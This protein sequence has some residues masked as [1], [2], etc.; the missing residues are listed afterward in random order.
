MQRG[1]SLIEVLLALVVMSAGMLGLAFQQLEAA[2]MGTARQL[3]SRAVALSNELI[4]SI[5]ANP[6]GWSGYYKAPGTAFPVEIAACTAATS[7]TVSELAA[8]EL[9]D[10]RLK[11]RR[12]M[13]QVTDAQLNSGFYICHDPDPTD[14]NVCNGDNASSERQ[15]TVIQMTWDSFADG[16]GA[17]TTQQFRVVFWP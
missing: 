10:W 8:R 2:Q 15:Q 9:F 14:V 3:Q 17:V 12:M 4:E 6:A 7:C 13:P 16:S 11:V 1:F 5:K